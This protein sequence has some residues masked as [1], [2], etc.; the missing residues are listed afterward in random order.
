MISIPDYLGGHVGVT[1]IDPPVLKDIQKKYNITSMVDVGCGPGGMKLLC[2]ALGIDWFGI[3]GDS[4]VM[5]T[6]AHGLLWDL[7]IGVPPIDK[8]FDLGWSTEF[9]EHIEEKYIPNFLPIFQ[10][11][12][13]VCCSGALPGTPGH[14]H[15][16]CQ[17]THY[18]IEVFDSY[19]FYYDED[20]TTLLRK[21]SVQERIRA[22][23]GFKKTEG[24]RKQFFSNT[25][26]FF[27]KK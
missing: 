10:K 1:K 9:L 24:R 15:V 17:P 8:T 12:K 2:D 20:Y 22:A 18:W 3:E 5:E 21:I 11:C 26:M 27:I 6:N 13:Y 25:G 23:D 14:H 16:N 4:N 19:G 7:T